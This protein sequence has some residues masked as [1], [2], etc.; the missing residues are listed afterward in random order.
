MT[1]REIMEISADITHKNLNDERDEKGDAFLV[2]RSLR[3]TIDEIS[4]YDQWWFLYEEFSLPIIAQQ[5]LY[6]FPT[7]NTLGEPAVLSSYDKQT[8]RT[9]QRGDIAFQDDFRELYLSYPAWGSGDTDTPGGVDVVTAIGRKFALWRTPSESYAEAS[10]VLY[11]S[12]WRNMYSFSDDEEGTEVKD[13]PAGWHYILIEGTVKWVLAQSRAPQNRVL[14]AR[15]V[16]EEKKEEMRR[17]CLAARGFANPNNQIRP[18]EPFRRGQGTRGN[19][20]GDYG[21]WR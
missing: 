4:E 1:Y 6:D 9:I 12:G 7:V 14:E 10:R 5:R 18:S 13:I 19:P 17:K 20:R 8:F 21:L 15:G 11:Y 3:A 2:R 16:F